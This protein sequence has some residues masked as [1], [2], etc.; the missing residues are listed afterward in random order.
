MVEKKKPKAKKPRKSRVGQKQKQIQIVTVNVPTPAVAE[1]PKRKTRAKP[2]PKT[3]PPTNTFGS[4]PPFSGAGSLASGQPLRQ[5]IYAPSQDVDHSIKS[6]ER[7]IEVLSQSGGSQAD[8]KSRRNGN[9]PIAAVGNAGEQSFKGGGSERD[10]D[11]TKTEI[12][13]R[14]DYQRDSLSGSEF[15]LKKA[16]F[17][18]T[19]KPGYSNLS[20]IAEE[21]DREPRLIRRSSTLSGLPLDQRLKQGAGAGKQLEE[22]AIFT[23]ETVTIRRPKTQTQTKSEVDAMLARD[24]AL[25]AESQ[26]RASELGEQGGGAE[27]MTFA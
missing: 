25:F 2:K 13:D 15:M 24:A 9:P 27:D 23:G 19:T 14:D 7:S 10:N 1:K 5:I 21:Q 4:S 18:P 8:D 11:E 17:R 26:K 12:G 3:T 16:G 6:L 20:P 22:E